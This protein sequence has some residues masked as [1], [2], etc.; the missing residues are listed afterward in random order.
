MYIEEENMDLE[1]AGDVPRSGPGE[2]GIEANRHQVVT[3]SGQCHAAGDICFELEGVDLQQRVKPQMSGEP[4]SCDAKEDIE[5]CAKLQR[6]RRDGEIRRT[7]C[8]IPE[9]GL[10]PTPPHFR[11]SNH[12][13]KSGA[14]ATS[15]DRGSTIL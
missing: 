4:E 1:F 13:Q 10:G 14:C 12:V 5:R 9:I 3:A 2:C 6:V 11:W 8:G 15:V 7:T